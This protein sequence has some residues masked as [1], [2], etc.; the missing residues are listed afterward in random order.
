[1]R[2]CLRRGRYAIIAAGGT[3]I[4]TLGVLTVSDSGAAGHRRDTS[5]EAIVQLLGE[6]RY[7]RRRYEVVPD[8]RSTIA[9]R[10][11]EWCDV[12]KLDLVV[13][14]GGTGL[15]PR[16]ITPEATLD[17]AERLVPG[18]A[19]AIRAET[20]RR[21]PMAIIGRG[22]AVTRGK[23]L[24]V[25]LPGSTRAVRECLEVLGPVLPHALDI[26]K[27]TATGHPTAG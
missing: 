13:T 19:E 26:L 2:A 12:D 14:T 5:G 9:A 6:P 16:D 1:M 21:S 7:Q 11:K 23:T 8:D 27:G 25:N 17:V 15:A 20:A 18:L 10:L 22:V 4:Y 3:T 24:I